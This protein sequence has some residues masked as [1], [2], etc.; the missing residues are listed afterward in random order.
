MTYLHDC[1]YMVSWASDVG[2]QG[3][4]PTQVMDQPIV[5]YRGASG[6]LFAFDDRCR[7]KL[8]PL[9]RGRVEGDA[10]RCM[11]HG[12]KYGPDGRCIQI[13]GRSDVP[14]NLR[15]RSYPVQEAHS[16]IWLWMGDPARADRTLIPPFE[17]IDHPEW[18]MI[19]GQ[20]DYEAHFSLINENLLDLSHVPFV[21]RNSFGGGEEIPLDPEVSIPMQEG[22]VTQLDRG[23]RIVFSARS[24]PVAPMLR[25][26]VG[27]VA[28][29]W[30]TNDF[31]VPGIFLLTIELFKPGS[32]AAAG[33]RRPADEMPLHRNFSCQAVTPRS[34]RRTTYF[35]AFGPWKKSEVTAEGFAQVAEMAFA[36]DR[37][38]I[39]AQQKVID[40]SPGVKPKLLH[41]DK[42][43]A[44][45]DAVVQ[46]LIAQE[47]QNSDRSLPEPA[48]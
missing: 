45:F 36:E 20:M 28:D 6:A 13:P 48:P 40:A 32:I 31:L 24:G 29:T 30:T 42:R 17:G 33:G 21:H 2:Q 11:Y 38:M 1:W 25:A 37:E 39:T 14:T 47:S 46:R 43:A 41:M 4:L 18:K 34:A 16:A 5:V 12:L 10:L 27:D 35:Y 44:M 8:A 19:P 9:S 7:H 15:V 26:E 22:E 3:V 23:L